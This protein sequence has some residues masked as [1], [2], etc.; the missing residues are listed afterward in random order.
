MKQLLHVSLA[1]LLVAFTSSAFA[2]K[3]FKEGFIIKAEGDTVRGLVEYRGDA[4]NAT[5]A[6][7]K[8]AAN[9]EVVEY[10]PEQIS[11]YGFK[12]SKHYE[13]QQ[14]D[15]NGKKQ[16]VFLNILVKGKASV[17]FL[18]EESEA[19]HFF[20]KKQDGPTV[21]LLN[22]VTLKRDAQTGKQYNVYQ[23]EYKKQLLS[24]FQE[25][26]V[27]IN[28]I[29]KLKLNYRDIRKLFIKYNECAAKEELVYVEEQINS[30]ATFGVY[31][32]PSYSWV[33]VSGLHYLDG[34]EMNTW[35]NYAVGGFM[36][37]TLPRIN[38]KISLQLE[39]QLS[40]R[41][42]KAE[43]YI[44][45][46][47]YEEAFYSTN[48]ELDYL[49]LPVLLRYQLP[50]PKFSPFLNVGISNGFAVK[51]V[52]KAVKESKTYGIEKTEEIDAFQF[53]RKYQ[54][55]LLLGTGIAV[56][57]GKRKAFFAEVRGE[58]TN[59]FNSSVGFSTRDNAVFLMLGTSF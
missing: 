56:P 51:T 32:A 59:G 10:M 19:T 44:K 55:G 3:N 23:M 18:K 8:P 5:V 41:H 7:F 29:E 6:V 9:A 40:R 46:T 4:R 38:D 45:P 13:T 57:Y 1:A 17:Y 34:V 28:D 52:N 12:G 42:F 22:T 47:S 25:C 54:Q 36:N 14:V 37:V 43:N 53:I 15:L 33:K 27:L 39:L 49:K 30:K 35:A 26:V 24:N 20:I 58:V 50:N 48:I 31:V 21:E 16:L 11:G 2:Q